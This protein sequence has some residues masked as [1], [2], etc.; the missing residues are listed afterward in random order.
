MLY[1]FPFIKFEIM[2]TCDT[3]FHCVYSDE[4]ELRKSFSELADGRTDSAS[5]TM[6]RVSSGSN[7]FAG[8]AQQPGALLYK[9]GFLVRKVHA[10]SDGKKSA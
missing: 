6:K 7:P 10:D 9:N 4:E 2:I 1:A 8:V 5:H 3:A